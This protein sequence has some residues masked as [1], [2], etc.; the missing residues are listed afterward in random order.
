MV[1]REL[2]QHFCF[3]V[4]NGFEVINEQEW[5]HKKSTYFEQFG[6]QAEESCIEMKLD[7]GEFQLETFQHKLHPETLSFCYYEGD[8]TDLL[9][10]V[11]IVEEDWEQY[12]F[13]KKELNLQTD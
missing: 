9:E 13:G 1:K 8:K 3:A 10:A 5:K 7:L 12:F 4:K 6:Y 2:N 11:R